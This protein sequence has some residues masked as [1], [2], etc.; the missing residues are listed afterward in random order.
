[1]APITAAGIPGPGLGADGIDPVTTPVPGPALVPPATM[2]GADVRSEPVPAP[3]PP[4]P[5]PAQLTLPGNLNL[6]IS[7]FSPGDHGPVTQTIGGP[8]AGGT[9]AAP[10]PSGEGLTP[11]ATWIWTWTWVGGPGCGAPAGPGGNAAPTLGIPGWTW[12]WDWS[13][14]AA[15]PVP[16]VP[17]VPTSPSLPPMPAMPAMPPLALLS[18]ALRPPFGELPPGPLTEPPPAMDEVP[19]GPPGT[20]TVAA[21][22]SDSAPRL[23]TSATPPPRTP[24]A[25]GFGDPAGPITSAHTAAATLWATAVAPAARVAAPRERATAGDITRRAR[26][27][28]APAGRD[29]G[30]GVP[31]LATAIA[32]PAGAAGGGMGLAVLAAILSFLCLQVAG[33]LLA[34]VGLPRLRPHAA[35]LERPG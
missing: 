33:A 27:G 9:G 19:P 3:S 31:P 24:P 28:R 4:G 29:E 32:A 34:G 5:A 13:C 22:V 12:I 15:A 11:P 10:L 18:P 20:A 30:P 26:S 14:G 16:S 25:T 23:L 8:V 17:G 35:R 1:V 7:I 2:G 21:P 6:S